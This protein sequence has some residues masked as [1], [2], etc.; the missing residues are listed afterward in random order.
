MGRDAKVTRQQLNPPRGAVAAW[1]TLAAFATG[2]QLGPLGLQLLRG[3]GMRRVAGVEVQ[4]P[5]CTPAL[6]P[7]WPWGEKCHCHPH[8]GARVP[9]CVCP[10]HPRQSW[11]RWRVQPGQTEG[12]PTA[13]PPRLHAKHTLVCPLQ[14]DSSVP[15]CFLAPPT[16]NTMSDA[17]VGHP[18]WP[19]A[20]GWL[21]AAACMGHPQIS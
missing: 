13:S 20:M 4:A 18:Q 2:S 11:W 5:R 9:S 14:G 12:S 16:H 1:T 6:L 17:H 8:Q 7:V 15:T 3:Q 10:C 21:M 19:L